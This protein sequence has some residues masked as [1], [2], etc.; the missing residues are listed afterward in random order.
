MTST[1][2]NARKA[3][4]MK[5][6]KNNTNIYLQFLAAERWSRFATK[7]IRQKAPEA[8][9]IRAERTRYV[10]KSRYTNRGMKAVAMV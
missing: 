8:I 2:I 7:T 9:N 4:K 5:A 3:S 10:Y 1:H 6:C